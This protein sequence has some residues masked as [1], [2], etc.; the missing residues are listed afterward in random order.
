MGKMTVVCL[1]L[2][3]HT[4]K[5]IHLTKM[6]HTS[7]Q[8]KISERLAP[9]LRMWHLVLPHTQMDRAGCTP[10]IAPPNVP[11]FSRPS[12]IFSMTAVHPPS[13]TPS[14]DAL[15]GTLA[16]L[17]ETFAA[18]FPETLRGPRTIG[19]EAE[20]PMVWPDGQAADIRGLWPL[21]MEGGDLKPLREGDLIVGLEG[22]SYSYSM[23][24]GW[25]TIEV[26][27]EPCN[28]LHALKA[29]HETAMAR[30]LTATKRYG[31][32]ILGYGIQ[33]ITPKAKP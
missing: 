14:A 29:L 16:E 3:L 10:Q 23:E 21:L 15:S 12:E 8:S 11:A 19:R 7:P 31:C 30:L 26:I 27:T 25:G 20:Y 28:D 17:A 18:R 6:D 1:Q 4:K 32:L 22:T 5:G 2:F 13:S 24:V 33:P 9:P